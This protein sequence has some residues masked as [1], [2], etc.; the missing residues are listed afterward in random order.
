MQ[1][2]YWAMDCSWGSLSL[3][4]ARAHRKW[5][6]R[7]LR[8]AVSDMFYSASGVIK[9]ALRELNSLEKFLG[10]K[11]PNKFSTQGGKKVPV[12]QNNSGPALTG[13]ITIASH[14][15]KEANR[16]ELLGENAEQRAVV[17][18]WLEFRVTKLDN[19]PKE[20]VKVILK[21][22]LALQE[23]ERYLNIA[24]WFDHIQHYPSIRHHLP[25]VVVLRN[26]VYPSG[27]H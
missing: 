8:L 6:L 7:A 13:L 19:C 27:H 21:V 16:P 26:R 25:L 20:E 9:M 12:L 15:V 3:A 4:R 10:L 11:K 14:L 17:Q 1:E 24:R 23:K 2:E 22:E 18:Q 5:Q